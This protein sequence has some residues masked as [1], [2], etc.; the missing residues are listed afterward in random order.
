MSWEKGM[1]GRGRWTVEASDTV[2]RDDKGHEGTVEC[3][4]VVECVVVWRGQ[5]EWWWSWRE[6]R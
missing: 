2:I 5:G 4:E 1:G 6:G 3:V